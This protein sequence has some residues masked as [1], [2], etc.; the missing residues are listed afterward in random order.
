MSTCYS[1]A[2]TVT[3]MR[4]C[5]INLAQSSA[6]DLFSKAPPNTPFEA[7]IQLTIKAGLPCS[8]HLKVSSYCKIYPLKE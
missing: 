5:V 7:T 2:Q 3:E 6:I 1:D 4:A 8:P